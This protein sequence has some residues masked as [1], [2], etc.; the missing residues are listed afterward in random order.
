MWNLVSNELR[1]F[2]WLASMVVALSLSGVGLAVALAL[3][4]VGIP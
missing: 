2:V 4:L 1:E 3:V